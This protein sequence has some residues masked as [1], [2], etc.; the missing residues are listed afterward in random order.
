[1][2]KLSRKLQKATA[3]LLAMGMTLSAIQPTMAYADTETSDPAVEVTSGSDTGSGGYT[4][5]DIQASKDDS[6]ILDVKTS[7]TKDSDQEI[8]LH[9]WEFDEGFFEDY[10]FTKTPEKNVTIN[11]LDETNTTEITTKSGEVVSLDYIIDAENSDYY[12]SFTAQAQTE[13]E[14]NI[15][16][17]DTKTVKEAIE[18]VVE[19]E[20]VDAGEDD[21]TSEPVKLTM[22]ATTSSSDQQ[23]DAIKANSNSSKSAQES[24]K[25][26]N[27]QSTDINTYDESAD[28]KCGENAYWEIDEYGTLI[29]SGTGPMYDYE[30]DAT[31]ST[32]APWFES[33]DYIYKIKVEE[34]ISYIG[35]AAFASLH[36]SN[37]EIPNSVTEIGEYVLLNTSTKNITLPF[38]GRSKE[39]TTGF[40]ST[41]A[42]LFGDMGKLAG[43]A[44]MPESQLEQM[45]TKAY[46]TYDG[47]TAETFDPTEKN[48]Y[49]YVYSAGS[50]QSIS[51]TNQITYSDFAFS[52]L[53]I[54]SL[55]DISINLPNGSTYGNYFFYNSNIGYLTVPLNTL[56][57]SHTFAGAQFG[58]LFFDPNYQIDTFTNTM[59]DGTICLALGMPKAL[60]TIDGEGN[61]FDLSSPYND[62]FFCLIKP[63]LK[64]F[65]ELDYINGAKNFSSALYIDTPEEAGSVNAPSVIDHAI[66][67]GTTKIGENGLSGSNISNITLPDSV[68][69]IGQNAFNNCKQLQAINLDQVTTIGEGAFSGCTVLNNIKLNNSITELKKETFK[70]CSFLTDIQLPDAL[71]DIFDGLFEGCISLSNIELSDD[72]QY[73]GN[74][75]FKNTGLTSIKIPESVQ[76]IGNYAFANSTSLT[77]VNGKNTIDEVLK[78]MPDTTI[79]DN[80]FYNTGLVANEKSVGKIF[81]VEKDGLTVTVETDESKNRTPAMDDNNRLLYYTGE[82]AT[83]TISISNPNGAVKEKDIIRILFSSSED[84]KINMEEGSFHIE[85]G[86]TTYTGEITK[87]NQGYTVEIEAPSAGDTISFSIGSMFASGTTG[88]GLALIRTEIVGNNGSSKASEG[89]QYLSWGTHPDPYPVNKKMR[90]TWSLTGSGLNDG[91]SYINGLSYT[92]TAARSG[93]TLE[94]IGEDP[95]TSLMFTDTLTLP[96]G[97]YISDEIKT[98]INNEELTYK[99]KEVL[100][101]DR[102]II[103]I[104]TSNNISINS[105]SLSEDGTKLIVKWSSA[106][107][108]AYEYVLTYGDKMFATDT[109]LEPEQKI[110]ITNDIAVDEFYTYSAPQNQ[111]SSVTASATAS[112]GS[113]D[114]VYK[115]NVDTYNTNLR[116][117]KAFVM[118]S[119]APY[120]IVLHNPGVTSTYVG[121]LSDSLPRQFYISGEGIESM[122]SS[123]TG[124]ALELTITNG[125][126]TTGD[127]V[128][129]VTGYDGG[130]HKTTI[131]DTWNGS[132]YEGLSQPDEESYTNDYATNNGVTITFQKGND[133]IVMTY[134]SNMYTIGAN[135]YYKTVDEALKSIN[136][137]NTY[138]TQYSLDWDF[139]NEN[140][141]IYGGET[142]EINIPSIAKSTFMMLTKD[143]LGQ[144]VDDDR[145]ITYPFRRASSN[146]TAQLKYAGGNDFYKTSSVT[147]LYYFMDMT[148]NLTMSNNDEFVE[149]GLLIKEGTISKYRNEIGLADNLKIDHIPLIN[150]IEGSQVLLV[151]VNENSTAEWTANAEIYTDDNGKQYYLLNHEGSYENV[152]VGQVY[153]DRNIFDEPL[154]NTVLIADKVI[155]EKTNNGL[156]TTIYWYLEK[157]NQ[158]KYSYSNS[159]DAPALLGNPGMY[160]DYSVLNSG[161]YAESSGRYYTNTAY[162]GDYQGHRLV[163]SF[164][165][166][167]FDIEKDI[168]TEVG[169]TKTVNNNST[170]G[171]G[172]TVTY[173][174]TM[175]STT[176]H[177]STVT[178]SEMSDILPLSIDSYR[179]TKDNVKISYS[180]FES[181]S[182]TSENSWSI[183][184]AQGDTNQ[185]NVKWNDNFK[186]SFNSPAYIWVTLTYPEGTEWEQ[187][188]NSYSGT[189]LTNTFKVDGPTNL[190]K[191]VTH[192]LKQDTEV[193]LQKGV[194]GTGSMSDTDIA[195]SN[196]ETSKLKF[197]TGSD[198]RYYY[199]NSTSDKAFVAYYVVLY[200]QGKSNLYLTDMTDILPEG[201]TFEYVATSRLDK[202]TSHED[203]VISTIMKKD[204]YMSII[205][206]NSDQYAFA[207]IT[208]S[209]NGDVKYVPARIVGTEKGN[210]V[211]F[212]FKHSNRDKNLASYDETV[213]LS[214]LKPGESIQFAYVCSTDSYDKTQDISNNA[215]AMPIYNRT[216][217]NI[218][219]GD[220]KINAYDTGADANDGGCTLIT[221]EEAAAKGFTDQADDTQ[222]VMSDVNVYRGGIKPGL[223]KK[224]VSSESPSGMITQ[225]PVVVN[226]TDT[227]EWDVT[228]HNSGNNESWIMQ[229]Q[230]NFHLH[231]FLAEMYIIIFTVPLT[232]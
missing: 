74:N 9:L 52:G 88:G 200:N 19:P 29:I 15:N 92:I 186:V 13:Y 1:M 135:G 215:I 63:D 188:L 142:I 44:G 150:Q 72:M 197:S 86:S 130:S 145:A 117:G 43:Q 18:F 8:R 167:S 31:E 107:T 54:T 49:T 80:A 116:D 40:E 78:T 222:W 57:Q 81:S 159:E 114:L 111:T 14:F 65:Y 196:I 141:E 121:D 161:K 140:R 20:I 71:T 45:F 216:G 191:T 100:L 156:K 211:T 56:I 166:V 179:W 139:D 168:V 201:Y 16:F 208:D 146:S 231:M 144:Y 89:A 126:I 217:G 220:S 210:T 152:Y 103:Q 176:D 209:E 132:I 193:L 50:I 110:D 124:D 76:K 232:K 99:G 203:G 225:S 85:V 169:D 113:I 11:S 41:F 187:Y 21:Q 229:S 53:S 59:F 96:A 33:A 207:T 223:S 160:I 189:I 62:G 34:G 162:L 154:N 101:G 55:V 129:D 131:D 83:T 178:G 213:G 5:I 205:T 22:P 195:S 133:C 157:L 51:V 153:G 90:D 30:L 120:Q 204:S 91:I 69:E 164:G 182:D 105:V 35:D 47:Y 170:I 67:A 115:L 42:Y 3:W 165:G 158:F 175:Y 4:S 7:N 10:E 32:N 125:T 46:H 12:I 172:D 104:T 227:L 134:D 109:R 37:I 123:E 214:Y 228:A 202:D 230:M 224:L 199:P 61:D 198:T 183:T 2:Q 194:Y 93:D 48:A 66:P 143:A 68:T 58:I 106:S 184:E 155:V 218:S 171:E 108:K 38:I 206:P 122:F 221:G 64:T 112:K 77:E 70:G 128:Y 174:L 17:E 149:D 28:N 98:A 118:G 27:V 127:S 181:I 97:W 177:V 73:I 147:N 119:D 212:S 163:D 136:F 39:D 23:S 6:S 36:T 60:K 102:T 148:L 87:T 25:A 94:G 138:Y 219:I 82:T 95:L 226:P 192:V 137:K 84:Y 173:R 79:S 26:K 185:Q 190:Q 151:P 180:G 75:A 24:K